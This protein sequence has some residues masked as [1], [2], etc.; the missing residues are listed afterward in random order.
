MG[1]GAAPAGMTCTAAAFSGSSQELCL[2]ACSAAD[3]SVC[4]YGTSCGDPNL[5]G[6]CSPA[7]SGVCTPWSPCALGGGVSGL[8]V[9]SGSGTVCIASGGV[10]Q[11]YGACDPQA[12]NAS[13]TALC[14]VGMICLANAQAP[15]TLRASLAGQAG[16]SCFPLCGYGAPGCSADQHCYDPAGAAY[17]VCLPGAPCSVGP[18]RCQIGWWCLPDSLDAV[19]GGCTPSGQDAGAPGDPCA[20]PG[21]LD[22]PCACVPGAACLPAPDGGTRCQTLCGL[23]AGRCDQ[24]VCAPVGDAGAAVLGGCQ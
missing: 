2:I 24:G 4:P 10:T 12:S 6:Y 17:G 21:Q 1:C 8:C 5:P 23:D 20:L 11:P 14:G 18:N 19:T 16:G 9:P 13:T 7:G 15:A 3:S 22:A